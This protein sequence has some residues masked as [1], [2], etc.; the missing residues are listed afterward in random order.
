MRNQLFC[1]LSDCFF[2]PQLGFKTHPNIIPTANTGSTLPNL[3]RFMCPFNVFV[4]SLM[5]LLS[6]VVSCQNPPAKE[7]IGFL[8]LLLKCVTATEQAHHSWTLHSIWPHMLRPSAKLQVFL[9]SFVRSCI[10]PMPWFVANLYACSFSSTQKSRILVFV[11]WHPDIYP[12]RKSIVLAWNPSFKDYCTFKQLLLHIALETQW[13]PPLF[14][15]FQE[16]KTTQGNFKRRKCVTKIKRRKMLDRRAFV[17]FRTES[18]HAQY[19]LFFK[20]STFL[21][22]QFIKKCL[23]FTS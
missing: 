2:W 17:M 6:D 18:P 13:N 14:Q 12:V 9:A 3:R 5:V 16:L 10:L 11:H 22:Y 21:I 20:R 19:I 4:L 7:E 1:L 15:E 23:L 8:H